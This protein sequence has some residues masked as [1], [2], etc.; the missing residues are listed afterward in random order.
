MSKIIDCITFFD[1][2][3]SEPIEPLSSV[4]ILSIDELDSVLRDFM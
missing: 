3:R 1:E 4:Q 2:N